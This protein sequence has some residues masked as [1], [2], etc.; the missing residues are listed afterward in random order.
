MALED[1]LNRPEWQL[2]AACRAPGTPDVFFP[3][4]GE[5]VETRE[6][7][8]ICSGCPVRLEC[9]QFALEKGIRFGI[10]GGVTELGRRR[11]RRQLVLIAKPSPQYVRRALEDAFGS[12]I[13]SVRYSRLRDHTS[14]VWVVTLDNGRVL[15]LGSSGR[16]AGGSGVST[17][18]VEM[19]FPP[20]E[21]G[22]ERGIVAALRRWAEESK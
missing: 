19:G 12:P 18:L 10:W 17:R 9:L 5:Y 1:L 22:I 15:I 14:K 6:A 4:R 11:L 3:G 13:R 7:K 8:R 16:L 20:V 21:E 2:K